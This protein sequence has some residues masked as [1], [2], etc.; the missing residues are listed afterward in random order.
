[1]TVAVAAAPQA[2]A[3]RTPPDERGKTSLR[4]GTATRPDS[5]NPLVASN[6]LGRI[7]TSM[8][9]DELLPYDAELR[10]LPGLIVD[11]KPSGDGRLWLLELRRGLRWSDGT[12]VT[13]RDVVHTLR[14]IK[15]DRRSRYSR[16]LDDVTLVKRFSGR[17]VGVRLET[18][19]ETPPVLPIPLLPRHIWSSVKPAEVRSFANDSPIGSG[20]FAASAPAE[21]DALTLKARENHWRGEATADE[22]TLTFYESQDEL[23]DALADGS[24]DVADDIGPEQVE[25][26]ERSADVEIRP[27]PATAF[28]SLGMNT[29]STAGDGEIA[30]REAR[31][32]RAIALALDRDE[33]RE[34]ALGT[35]GV[36]GST[37]VPPAL[38]QH[39]SPAPSAELGF[40]RDRAAALLERAGLSDSDGDGLRETRLGLPLTFR[41]YTRRSLPETTVVGDR[42]AEALRAIGVEVAL[43]EL[44]DRELSRRIRS[45]R[46]DLFIWGWDVGSDPSFIASVL[47]CGEALP[48]GLSD[49]F[50]CDPDYDELYQSYVASK[51][52]VERQK[53]LAGMQARAYNRA[54][55][56]VLYYR[57]TFQAYRSDRFEASADA[58]API[59]F[60]LPP[61][62]PINLEPR[63]GAPPQAA[64]E[65]TGGETAAAE[66][67]TDLVDE[68]RSSLLWRILAAA[69]VVVLALLL[70]PRLI[71]GILWLARRRRREA[72]ET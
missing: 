6:R 72:S 61:A 9:Y 29:G 54:P 70:V 4:I 67:T 11:W 19:S 5:L 48:S 2:S 46:Y 44:T 71:R 10:P 37:I 52:S 31:V 36:T 18:P 53:L 12:A 60:A 66:P 24:I 49:T 34:L 27:A 65:E 38:P 56:V 13:A 7:L 43:S 32:R 22:V 45:G 21:A 20:S 25:R 16:W 15:S 59:V 58:S 63:P 26:L 42:I 30:L 3:G 51:S 69:G 14:R 68:V 35:Y 57:P 33:L 41:L 47:S 28:V 17:R 64:P 40:D 55:Y 23:A 8:L 50:F 1:M 39:A 62:Q